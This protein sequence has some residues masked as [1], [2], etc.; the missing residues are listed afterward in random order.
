[1]LATIV[2]LVVLNLGITVGLAWVMSNMR[3]DQQIIIWVAR[4]LRAKY[5]KDWLS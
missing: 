5:G 2:V 3:D 1:M 4:Q